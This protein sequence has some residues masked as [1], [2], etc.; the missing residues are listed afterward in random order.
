MI[1]YMDYVSMVEMLMVNNANCNASMK[2]VFWI[3]FLDNGRWQYGNKGQN[4]FRS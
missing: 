4:K 3:G 1:V 2:N